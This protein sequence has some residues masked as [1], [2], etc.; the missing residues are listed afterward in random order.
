MQFNPTFNGEEAGLCL[1]QKDDNYLLFDVKE[2]TMKMFF[3]L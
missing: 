3:D 1:I 2:K